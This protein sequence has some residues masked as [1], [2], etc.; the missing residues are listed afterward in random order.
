MSV[1][2]KI[3]LKTAYCQIPIDNNFKRSNDDKYVDR[4]AEIEK[5][6]ICNKNSKCHISKNHRTGSRRR[7]KKIWFV[8]KTI[9]A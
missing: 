3:D 2:T 4:V 7:Y 1:L 5:N 9:H 6:A 8:T